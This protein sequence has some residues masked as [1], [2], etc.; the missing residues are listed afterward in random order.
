MVRPYIVIMLRP[1]QQHLHYLLR[2]KMLTLLVEQKIQYK[3]VG[4]EIKLQMV[5]R[6]ISQ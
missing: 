1:T 3:L 4:T 2:Q 5:M 6:F